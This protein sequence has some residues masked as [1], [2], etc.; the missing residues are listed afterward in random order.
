MLEIA[1]V[2]SGE[3][4]LDLGSGTGSALIAAAAQ[5]ARATGIEINP[6]FVWYSRW[7]IRRHGVSHLASVARWAL[8]EYP[9]GD[10]DVIFR[11]LVPSALQRLRGK[12]LSEVKPGI[13][14]VSYLFPIAGWMPEKEE[15]RIFLYVPRIARE[16]RT[17]AYPHFRAAQEAKISNPASLAAGFEIFHTQNT[18]VLCDSK[19]I[20][21]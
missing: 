10:A 14:I 17:S 16:M 20:Q 19:L 13:R 18:Q 8:F 9:V 4:M 6:F 11:V 1:G 2:K 5:G 3:L 21:A 15:D 7:R 12:L